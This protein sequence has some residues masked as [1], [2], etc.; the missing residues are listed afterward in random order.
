MN[1]LGIEPGP[2]V[3]IVTD[4]LI[5]LRIEEGSLSEEQVRQKLHIWWDERSK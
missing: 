4:W 5:N 2:D 1:E 3:G